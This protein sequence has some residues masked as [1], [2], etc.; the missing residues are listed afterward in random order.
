MAICLDETG[1]VDVA[2]VAELLGVDE[3]QA[4]AKLSDHLFTDPESGVLV[5]AEEYLSGNVRAKLAAA[6]TAADTSD[7][8]AR[9]VAALEAVQPPQIAPGDIS[10][11]PGATWIPPGDVEAFVRQVLGIDGVTVSYEA[12]LGKWHVQVPP[13]GRPDRVL[14]QWSTGRRAAS[15]LFEASLNQRMVTVYDETPDGKRVVNQIET[16]AAREKQEALAERFATWVWDDPERAARLAERLQRAVQLLHRAPLHRRAPDVPG[17]ERQ[18]RAPPPPARRRGPDL[19]GRPLPVGPRGR[20]RQN[21]NDGHGRPRA[22]AARAREPARLPGAQP[23]IGA[24]CSRVPPALP[25]RQGA[26]HHQ[27]PHRP[28]RPPDLHQPLRHR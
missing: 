17:A 27:G 2:R 24:V 20:C 4:L 10:A 25:A 12:D 19:A 14:D 5:P 7:E 8:F 16:T 11:R 18:L 6:R 13:G 22:P 21:R 26:G 1:T 23:S 3:V 15:A 9:N 28:H